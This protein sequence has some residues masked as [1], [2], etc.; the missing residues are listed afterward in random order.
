MKIVKQGFVSPKAKNNFRYNAWPTV[1]SLSDGTL[2][3]GWSGDRFKH[4]CPFGRV[5]M[6]RSLDGGYT[7]LP[8]YCVQDTPLDDRDAGLLQVGDRII[9]TSVTNNR[10]MQRKY[11]DHW[12]HAPST[13]EKK[14]FVSSYIELITDEDEEKY[15]GPTI[16][17]S[18]DNASSFSDPKII[19]LTC[20][21][22]PM[23]TSDGRILFVGKLSTYSGLTNFENGIYIMELDKELNIIDPLR[24]IATLPEDLDPTSDWSEPH[25]AEMPNGDILVFIRLES[26]YDDVH[27][28]YTMRSTDGGK[29]FS[30]PVCTGWSGYPAH[31]FVDSKQRVIVTH[32]CRHSENMGIR[33]RVSYDNGY[34]FGEEIVLRGD[35][36][37]WD[38]GYPS[39]TENAQGQLVTVYYM[40]EIDDVNEN[41][42]QYT[43]WEI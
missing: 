22:G 41:R 26:K 27:T 34:T 36:L 25:A 40:K 16:S 10:D 5:M 8:P 30:K 35:G 19:P 13:P 24:L 28:L 32:G 31:I 42:I 21:H 6:S 23:K 37:D 11:L 2:L 3:A 9:M 4:I 43:I 20:P 33:A 38:L 18:T 29:T 17:V 39:T 14:A 1:I 15:L 7:W 12:L